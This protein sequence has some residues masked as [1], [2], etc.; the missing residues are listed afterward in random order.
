[1]KIE[2]HRFQKEKKSNKVFSEII[3]E[4][5]REEDNGEYSQR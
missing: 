1:M 5:E 3:H 4:D 2:A